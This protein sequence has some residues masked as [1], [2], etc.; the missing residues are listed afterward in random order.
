MKKTLIF[1]CIAIPYLSTH[2]QNI[3]LIWQI[4]RAAIWQGDWVTELLDGANI[5]NVTYDYKYEIFVNNAVVIVDA[6]A[7]E[8]SKYFE[9]LDKMNYKYGIIALGDE[10]YKAPSDYYKHAQ[11][12]FREYWHKKF[13]SQKNV[14]FIP[15]GYKTGFWKH[16]TQQFKTAQDRNYVWSFAGQITQKPTRRAMINVMKRIPKYYIH[17]TFAFGGANALTVNRYQD[18]LLDTVFVPCPTGWWN[19]DSFRVYEALEC[20]CI[21]IVERKPIDYFGHYFGKHP[22]LVIDSWEQAPA[23]IK[24]LMANP[25]TLE[26]YRITCHQWWLDYKEKIK[27]ELHTAIENTLSH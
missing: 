17:E 24:E 26:Q 18:M 6:S 8:N 13:A 5:N 22:F 14:H 9:K 11:F 4:N 16:C 19:L 3:N 10:R 25:S 21:P 20:G 1:A 2:T 23:L 12:V 27:Q 7:P 15:L